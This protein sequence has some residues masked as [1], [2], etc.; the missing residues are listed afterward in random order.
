MAFTIFYI[1]CSDQ[2]EARN[3]SN[4]LLGKRLIACVNIFRIESQFW[5]KGSIDKGQE[6]VALMKTQHKHIAAVE[7][8]IN[9]HH[10]YETPC[11]IRWEVNANKAYE[12]WIVSETKGETNT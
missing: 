12:D 2:E 4:E 1:T 8:F 11:I 9:A 3:L 5:W 7:A 10:S 6:W